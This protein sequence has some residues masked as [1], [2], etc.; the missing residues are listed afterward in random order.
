MKT[1]G[2]KSINKNKGNIILFR[3]WEEAQSTVQG[4]IF[5]LNYYSGIGNS[6]YSS[7]ACLQSNIHSAIQRIIL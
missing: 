6:P 4:S 7:F 3:E 5:F 1:I 2:Y